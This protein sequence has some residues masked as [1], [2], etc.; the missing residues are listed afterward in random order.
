MTTNEALPSLAFT[1]LGGEAAEVKV[2]L[3]GCRAATQHM[4]R[5]RVFK[6][7]TNDEQPE[8]ADAQSPSDASR[9]PCEKWELFLTDKP[10]VSEQ[11]YPDRI[12][13]LIRGA[14]ATV[15]DS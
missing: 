7:G 1:H 2:G 5:L 11:A 6:G 9:F 14:H 8:A 13:G 15:A 4:P 3:A 10:G 12:V